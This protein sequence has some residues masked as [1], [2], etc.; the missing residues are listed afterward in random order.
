M[1]SNVD[2]VIEIIRMDMALLFVIYNP[3]KCKRIIMNY[4]YSVN[5]FK[6]QGLPVYTLELV[7]E[8]EQPEILDAIHVYGNSY[9]FHKEL[10]Y[11]ILEKHIPA[12]YTKL[13]F[14]DCDLLFSNLS[15]YT[16]TTKLLDTFDVVQPFEF[17]EWLDLTYKKVIFRKETVL[18]QYTPS[19]NFGKFHPGF[20]WCIKRSW[21]NKIGF[22]DWGVIGSGDCLTCIGWM[23]KVV[24]KSFEQVVPAYRR[25]F[26]EFYNKPSPN[27]TFVAGI[28]V[29]HLHHGS[30]S[31]RQYVSRHKL[32]DTQEPLEKITRVNKFGVLEWIDREKF[33]NIFL[34]YFK[35]R[36][37][38]DFGLD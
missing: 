15:W 11:R 14:L 24:P 3:M 13:A 33:N 18:K 35:T 16:Q 17:A 27:M 32:L 31:K 23:K 34:G 4:H 19:P 26:E 20:A 21:Y 28:T 10:L 36:D 6:R 25:Q 29:Q 38:D 7:F 8:G 12:N 5:I 2:K 37:D 22:F 1:V 9:M 30:R